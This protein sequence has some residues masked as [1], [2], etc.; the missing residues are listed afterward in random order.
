[1]ALA[2]MKNKNRTD[3]ESIRIK[4][5]AANYRRVTTK[6]VQK[7]PQS[8]IIMSFF[9]QIF[10]FVTLEVSVRHLWYSQL[11]Q[12]ICRRSVAVENIIL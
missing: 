3:G 9:I 2:Q 1:M 10:I 5:I 11:T 8:G 7:V 6:A 4:G 12:N